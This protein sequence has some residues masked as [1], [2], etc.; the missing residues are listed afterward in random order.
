MP[1]Y[2][3]DAARIEPAPGSYRARIY[4]GGL[5]SLS[6]DGLILAA[7]FPVALA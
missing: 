2:F 5:S 6:Q 1:E 7:L 4:Y 3:P